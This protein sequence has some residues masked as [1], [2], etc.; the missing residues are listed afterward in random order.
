METKG[1]PVSKDHSVCKDLR[2]LLVPQDRK[3]SPG[4]SFKSTAQLDRKDH[5]VLRVNRARRE[6][7]VRTEQTS[8]EWPVLRATTEIL[9]PRVNRDHKDRLANLVHRASLEAA[10]T[11]LRLALLLATKHVARGDTYAAVRNGKFGRHKNT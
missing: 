11:A 4:D 3:D 10:S 6:C 8:V 9:D 5:Q 1:H 7:L 2:D